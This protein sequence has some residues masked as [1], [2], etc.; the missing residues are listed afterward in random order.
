MTELESVE[1]TGECD[2]IEF[3]FCL[4]EIKN[5]AGWCWQVGVT[6]RWYSAS[7]PLTKKIQSWHYHH[8]FGVRNC[9]HPGASAMSRDYIGMPTKEVTG[10][11]M[12]A[13]LAGYVWP[14]VCVCLCFKFVSY[15]H[16]V[17]PPWFKPSWLKEYQ[18]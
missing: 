12:I 3:T 13:A 1:Y 15:G 10:R 6:S 4:V 14:K 9:F 7:S 2:K 11:E 8:K 18:K 5:N 17:F 16:M